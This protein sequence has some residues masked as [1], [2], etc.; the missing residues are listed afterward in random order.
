MVGW[1][2]Q[3]NRHE[4]EQAP[5]VGYGQESLVCCSLW[6]RKVGHNWAAKL[7]STFQKLCTV[8]FTFFCCTVLWNL[9]NVWRCLTHYNQDAEQLFYHCPRFPGAATCTQSFLLPQPLFLVPVFSSSRY[10]TWILLYTV[11]GVWSLA[12]FTY[13]NAFE[14]IHV[15]IYL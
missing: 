4:F 13:H 12:S 2:H 10:C 7:N 15:A 8:K 9:R 14:F 5:G 6:G 3:H 1:P 11:F